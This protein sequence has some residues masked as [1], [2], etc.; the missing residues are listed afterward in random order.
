MAVSSS[1]IREVG[2]C[3]RELERRHSL[4]ATQNYVQGDS[5][6]DA[7]NLLLYNNFVPSPLS[8]LIKI[9]IELYSRPIPFREVIFSSFC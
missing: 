3:T 2:H 7:G 6:K 1:K 5:N 4:S 8:P 9:H